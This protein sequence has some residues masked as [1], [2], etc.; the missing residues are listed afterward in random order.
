MLS[1]LPLIS[2]TLKLTVLY[3]TLEQ[4]KD[5]LVIER[6]AIAQL[7]VDALSDM[8]AETKTVPNAPKYTVN[9]LCGTGTGLIRSWCWMLI[10]TVSKQPLA[11][12]TCA[13]YLPS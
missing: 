3:P 7:S 8:L 4:L 11:S 9:I 10:C 1:L 5:V 6:E 2:T 13:A 12:F